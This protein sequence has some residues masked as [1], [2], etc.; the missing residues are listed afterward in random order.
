VRQ[1]RHLAVTISVAIFVGVAAMW[2]MWPSKGADSQEV[3]DPFAND[4]VLLQLAPGTTFHMIEEVYRRYGA[5]AAE[6]P[7]REGPETQR[8]EAWLTFDE[9]GN[10]LSARAETRG[11]D[12]ALLSTVALEGADL[13]LRYAGG[14]E[15]HRRVDFKQAT[16][17]EAL[18]DTIAAASMVAYGKTADQREPLVDYGAQRVHVVEQR[19]PHQG[20]DLPKGVVGY[21]L[22]YVSDLDAVDEIRREY[23]LPDSYRMIRSERVV[24]AADGTETVVESREYRVLEVLSKGAVQ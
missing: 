10:L 7:S 11:V 24:V 22:P 4:P 20:R 5:K 23:V 17:V 6:V 18:K 15:R 8:T 12:G 13:V 14:E 3:F 9:R 1:R 2:A 19:S 21:H 16:T